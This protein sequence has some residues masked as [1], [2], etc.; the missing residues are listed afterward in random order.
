MVHFPPESV[1]QFPQNIHKDDFSP[2]ERKQVDQFTGQ[3]YAIL[4]KDKVN[5]APE[6][7]KSLINKA[8]GMFGELKK[9]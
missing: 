5:H 7:L 2:E 9:Q 8:Q 3:Y 6:E 1:V 4:A